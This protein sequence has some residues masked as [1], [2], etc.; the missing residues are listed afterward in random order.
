MFSKLHSLF[1]HFLKNQFIFGKGNPL[2]LHTKPSELAFISIYGFSKKEM[3]IRL[4]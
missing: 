2:A 1:K 4:N 3:K